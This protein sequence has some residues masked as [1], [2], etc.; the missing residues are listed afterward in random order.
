MQDGKR[1]TAE[2]VNPDVAHPPADATNGRAGTFAPLGTLK[3]AS[4]S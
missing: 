1:E 4:A 2:A 3:S